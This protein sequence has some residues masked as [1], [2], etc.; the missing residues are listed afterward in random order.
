MVGIRPF[1]RSTKVLAPYFIKSD[2]QRAINEGLFS[3]YCNIICRYDNS[4]VKY[5]STTASLNSEVYLV[6]F[7]FRHKPSL[8]NSLNALIQRRTC[9][10]VFTP[11]FL[12]KYSYP[13]SPFRYAVTTFN[14]NIRLY[15]A[16]EKPTSLTLRFLV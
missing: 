2:F 9:D 14:L 15:F 5:D 11:Y 10:V 1:G 16:I 4:L 12:V 6:L 3:P 13:P 7:R 8:P